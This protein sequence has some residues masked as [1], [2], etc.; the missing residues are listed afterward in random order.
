[1][2][3]YGVDLVDFEPIVIDDVKGNTST[4]YSESIS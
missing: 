2:E 4:R 1:M 3:K